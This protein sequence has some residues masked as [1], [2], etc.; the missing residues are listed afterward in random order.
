LKPFFDIVV[1]ASKN[2]GA[3]RGD[4]ALANRCIDSAFLSIDG[5]IGKGNW[6]NGFGEAFI[7]FRDG[8]QRYYLSLTG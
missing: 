2:E 4:L 8:M 7:N 1:T 3:K 5:W 6:P